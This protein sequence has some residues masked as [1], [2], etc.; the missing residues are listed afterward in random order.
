VTAQNSSR[1]VAIMGWNHYSRVGVIMLISVFASGL[2][3]LNEPILLLRT[4]G[5]GPPTC[6]SLAQMLAVL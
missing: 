5:T 6:S 1:D 4:A 2:L 3:P